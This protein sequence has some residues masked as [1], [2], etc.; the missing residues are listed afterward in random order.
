MTTC[1]VHDFCFARCRRS[2]RSHPLHAMRGKSYS[3]QPHTLDVSDSFLV[4]PGGLVWI[5][6]VLRLTARLVD[7]VFSLEVRRP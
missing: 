2:E 1:M 6:V 4:T 3:L 7:A 5:V